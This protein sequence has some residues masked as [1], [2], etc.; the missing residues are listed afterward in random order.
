MNMKGNDKL[1]SSLNSLF[2]DE[3]TAINQYMVHSEMCNDRGYGKL[4]QHFQKRAVDEMKHAEKLIGRI[5]FL[6]ETPVV[7]N[8]KQIMI[9]STVDK[10]LANN[11]SAEE[12]TSKAYNDA[13]VLAA[14]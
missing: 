14:R 6:E 2:A 7:T 1:L 10:Q 4:H 11:H 5:L 12:S 13:I 3:Q 9:G 8:L